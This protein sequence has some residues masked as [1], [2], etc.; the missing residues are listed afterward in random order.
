[1]L[2]RFLGKRNV[3][4]IG[5]RMIIIECSRTR[6]VMN[7]EE[8]KL[9]RYLHDATHP[10]DMAWMGPISRSGQMWSQTGFRVN[11]FLGLRL[12][13]PGTAWRR[14]SWTA[15]TWPGP[16]TGSGTW[17]TDTTWRGLATTKWR[18]NLY[19]SV[20]SC[21]FYTLQLLILLAQLIAQ[22]YLLYYRLF[23]TFIIMEDIFMKDALRIET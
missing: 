8:A 16:W 11:L 1:M 13:S 22:W 3:E 17:R 23:T 9:E 10:R 4:Y 12:C 15:S 20:L 14:R 18:N 21:I 7:V 6:R 5:W 2:L 19:W